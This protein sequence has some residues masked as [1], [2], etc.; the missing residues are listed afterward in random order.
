[1][2]LFGTKNGSSMASLSS[3][4]LDESH[5]LYFIF[6]MATFYKKVEQFVALDYCLW[7]NISIITQLSDVRSSTYLAL[8]HLCN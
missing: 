7:L 2:V 5:K 8:F 4:G 3:V 6:K 1:M